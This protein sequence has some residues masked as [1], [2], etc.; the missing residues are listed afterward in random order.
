MTKYVVNPCET[1]PSPTPTAPTQTDSK[2]TWHRLRLLEPQ[3][4]HKLNS[5]MCNLPFSTETAAHMHQRSL[6]RKNFCAQTRCFQQIQSEAFSILFLCGSH[7]ESLGA[8]FPVLTCEKGSPGI[9]SALNWLM[10]RSRSACGVS[11]A[12]RGQVGLDSE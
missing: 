5:S 10:I 2:S 1:P 6:N 3:P 8:C 12:G 7:M 9:G 11:C 4:S